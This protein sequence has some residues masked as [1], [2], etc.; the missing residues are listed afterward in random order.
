MVS[1][2]RVEHVD[3]LDR[4]LALEALATS[5][6]E[7]RVPSGPEETCFQR[8]QPGV[9]APCGAPARRR[10]YS[11]SAGHA[12]SVSNDGERNRCR[13]SA[14]SHARHHGI[15]ALVHHGV[16]DAGLVFLQK[17]FTPKELLRRVRDVLDAG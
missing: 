1:S 14:P 11:H 16:L 3:R 12:G 10:P 5:Q 13:R 2:V 9:G 6:Y 15:Y 8:V 17:P 4:L 7:E